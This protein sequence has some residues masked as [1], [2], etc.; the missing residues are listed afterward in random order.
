MLY[1]KPTFQIA[2]LCLTLLCV[3]V[4]WICPFARGHVEFC[5][6]ECAAPDWF[7]YAADFGRLLALTIPLFALCFIN[8][9]VADE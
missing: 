9:P 8:Q 6:R 3:A 4:S 7:D 5:D 2:A 1:S